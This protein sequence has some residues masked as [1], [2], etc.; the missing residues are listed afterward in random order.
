[1]KYTSFIGIDVSKLTLDIA[2]LKSNQT[3][4]HYQIKNDKES[5]Q[6]FFEDYLVET[7]SCLFCLEATGVYGVHLLNFTSKREIDTWVVNPV[8]IKR[9]VGMVRGKSD[10]IDAIRIAQFAKKNLDQVRLYQPQREVIKQLRALARSREQLVKA[11]TQLKQTLTES[12]YED[13]CVVELK[14]KAVEGSI[15]ALNKDIKTIEEDI[16]KLIKTD[17]KLSNIYQIA[18]S[19]IGIGPIT[20]VEIILTTNEF[21]TINDAK[22]FACHSGVAPFPNSSGTSL[23]G[24]NRVSQMANKKM[25]KLL[26]LAALSS[27]RYHNDLR[28]YFDRKVAEGKHKMSV[29]N[30]I[31]NKI[32]NRLFACIKQNRKYQI[33]LPLS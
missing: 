17:E 3:T 29:L 31:R 22:K 28:V 25:K 26:H 20:A 8:H 1:M 12:K 27:I 30:A 32:L 7:D 16:Q 21:K 33:N 10:Q 24:K 19:V 2:I 18:C 13:I 23:R 15:L 5:I 14:R 6:D 11:R 9:S 4:N